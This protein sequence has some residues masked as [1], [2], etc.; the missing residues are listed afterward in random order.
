MRIL[1]ICISCSPYGG[2]ED[3]VGWNT[4]LA[5][6]R[7][8]ADVTV[9]TRTEQRQYIERWRKENPD[10]AMPRFEYVPV[11]KILDAKPFRGQ[12]QSLRLNPWLTRVRRRVVELTK[13]EGFDVVHQVTPVEFRAVMKP[14]K[15]EGINVV[16]P[17]GGGGRHAKELDGYLNAGKTEAIRAAVNK[18]VIDSPSHSA[19]LRGYDIRYFANPDT[20]DCLVGH[21]STP[22][23][24]VVTD[25]GCLESDICEDGAA[26]T[27]NAPLKLL[28]VGRLVPL[29]G[30]RLLVEALAKLPRTAAYELRVYG[31]GPERASLEAFARESGLSQV[32][33]MGSINHEEVGKA[34]EWAD[35]FVFPSIRDA[36]GVVLL[37]AISHGLPVIA[38]KQF[39][40]SVVL[41]ETC[42]QLVEPAEGAE[43]F[44]SAIG[45]WVDG[46]GSPSLPAR[47]AVLAR[48]RRFTWE[49]KAADFLRDYTHSLRREP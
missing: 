37:E 38:F 43:G 17:L 23:D 42:A 12:F 16:G 6:M 33:F 25:V 36:T 9:I 31:D 44:A 8:G 40:A 1:Y 32:T 41:D 39:G 21:G 7:L 18:A 45:R 30:V 13:A 27:G 15:H 48:S 29:K 11:P 35:V 10:A 26:K 46:G 5:A 3:A 47:G 49:A 19:R 14:V 28:F 20:R 22:D 4:P 34:Y 2:S 24:P